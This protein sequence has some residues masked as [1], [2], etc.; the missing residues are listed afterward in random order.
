MNNMNR[1]FLAETEM[2]VGSVPYNTLFWWESK[3]L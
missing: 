1:E 2:F 3:K